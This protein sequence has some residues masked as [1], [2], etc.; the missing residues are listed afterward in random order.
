VR[1]AFA[2]R[3]TE[4]I[5]QLIYLCLCYRKSYCRHTST[6]LEYAY[7]LSLYLKEIAPESQVLKYLPGITTL[8]NAYR[9]LDWM[10][11]LSRFS[12]LGRMLQTRN[13]AHKIEQEHLKSWNSEQSFGLQPNYKIFN[14]NRHEQHAFLWFTEVEK[15]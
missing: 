8:L 12:P 2:N 13:I 6:D 11:K 4:E 1:Y 5:E 3:K 7:N 15:S 9:E 14:D 10:S